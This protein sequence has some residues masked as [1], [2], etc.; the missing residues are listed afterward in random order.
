MLETVKY[1]RMC[2]ALISNLDD[3]TT[4]YYRHIR[5]KYCPTCRETADHLHGLDRLKRYRQRKKQQ[6]QAT[7]DQLRLLQE[8][9]ELLRQQI[10]KLRQA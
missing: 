4:D 6:N 2:G 3:P 7:A 10:A 5:V 8:E 1:C 9:N